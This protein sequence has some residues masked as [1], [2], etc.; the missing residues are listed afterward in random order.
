[1]TVRRWLGVLVGLAGLVGL[2]IALVAYQRSSTA[3]VTLK[4]PAPLPQHPKIQVYTNHNPASE[5]TDA[6]RH[7]TR[8]GDDLEQI[9]IDAIQS[10]RSSVDVAVQELR[11]PRLAAALRDRQQTGVRV[12]VVLENSYTRPHSDYTV[13]ELQALPARERS[14]IEAGRQGIDSNQ[15]SDLSPEEISQND[16]LVILQQA[17]IPMIDDRADGSKGSALMHHKFVVIDNRLVIATSANFTLS[18][19]VGDFSSPESRGNANTLLRIDSPQLA[20]HFAQEFALLWGDG[21]GGLPNSRFGS[22][23]PY[24]PP[25]SVMVDQTPIDLQFSPQAAAIPWNTTSN[26]LIA[27][28]LETAQTSIDLALFVFSDQLLANRLEPLHNR[29]VQIRALIEPDFIFRPYS[30]ALDMLGISLGQN[31]ATELTNQPWQRPLTTVGVPRLPPGD[32]LHHKFAVVD[33]QTVIVGSHNWSTA[34]NRSNDEVVLVIH[35][36]IVAAHF[37]QEFDRLAAE[38]QFGSPARI[39]QQ[40]WAHQHC[41]TPATALRATPSPSERVDLNTAT[42][43]ELDALPGISPTVAQRIVAQRQRRS[44]SSLADLDEVPGIGPKTLQRLHDRVT[45]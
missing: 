29:G 5:F 11:L 3:P 2:A 6:Y 30:E 25:Q 40:A 21:P 26:G 10:A 41:P 22:R 1:M 24:R 42:V 16:A 44:F 20:S 17:G 4:R 32:L 33:R 28:T 37:Q 39:Q 43:A 27:K 31:C 7:Q 45:W 13:S 19:L 23:K 35:S 18:D 36:P 9:L 38:A 14:R 12:R 8:S 34:A 15:D